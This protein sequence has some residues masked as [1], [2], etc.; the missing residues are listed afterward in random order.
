MTPQELEQQR[1]RA[2]GLASIP[3]SA[4]TAPTTPSNRAVSQQTSLA[5]IGAYFERSRQATPGTLA[6]PARIDTSSAFSRDAQ[7]VQQGSVARLC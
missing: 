2:S 5:T 3:A 6:N 4:R 1:R 7:R